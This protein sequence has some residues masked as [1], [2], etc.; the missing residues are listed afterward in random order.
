MYKAINKILNTLN[1]TIR[2]H[3]TKSIIVDSKSSVL[4][5]I[6][7]IIKDI[8]GNSKETSKIMSKELRAQYEKKAKEILYKKVQKIKYLEKLRNDKEFFYKQYC[9]IFLGSDIKIS[10]MVL[11]NQKKVQLSILSSNLKGYTSA[12]GSTVE[13]FQHIEAQIYQMLLFKQNNNNIDIFPTEDILFHNNA[14]K[15]LALAVVKGTFDLFY[16][17]SSLDNL[18]KFSFII[19]YETFDGN[20]HSSVFPD[21]FILTE[22]D[23]SS[24]INFYTT[25]EKISFYSSVLRFIL[26]LTE[27]YEGTSL[28]KISVT[29]TSIEWNMLRNAFSSKQINK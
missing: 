8:S 12:L 19:H 20:S 16:N 27:K 25:P 26:Y 9:S 15:L 1:V 13:N 6:S 29:N 17:V 3:P 28:Y 22:E 14:V 10:K 5:S 7:D 18:N 23:V 4:L 24:S 21:S 2:L 11:A